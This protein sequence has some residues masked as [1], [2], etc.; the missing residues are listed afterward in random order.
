MCKRFVQEVHLRL[1]IERN[2]ARVVK[3]Q[4]TAQME[5]FGQNPMK[6]QLIAKRSLWQVCY[7]SK[8]V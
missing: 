1:R 7:S 3:E 5:N 2:K 6:E 8:A 4:V